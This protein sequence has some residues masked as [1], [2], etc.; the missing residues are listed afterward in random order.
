MDP[1]R[2]PVDCI[3]KISMHLANEI[4]EVVNNKLIINLKSWSLVSAR[5]MVIRKITIIKNCTSIGDGYL[6]PSE[7]A[8][9]LLHNEI[10]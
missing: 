3:A 1:C 2:S 5:D 9:Y 8:A 7:G 6:F 10:T 4:A